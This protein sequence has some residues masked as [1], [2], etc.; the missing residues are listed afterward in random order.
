[1]VGD[2]YIHAQPVVLPDFADVLS[3]AATSGAR[4]YPEEVLPV[5][6]GEDSSAGGAAGWRCGTSPS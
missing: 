1:M 2:P 4:T 3:R 6:A 5:L